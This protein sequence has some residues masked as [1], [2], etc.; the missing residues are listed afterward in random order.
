[1]LNGIDL[2]AIIPTG[3]GKT[4]VVYLY[5][6]ALQKLHPGRKS[7]VIAILAKRQDSW[8]GMGWE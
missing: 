3:S 8:D 5:A 4:I 7:M 1:M 6:I 2:T